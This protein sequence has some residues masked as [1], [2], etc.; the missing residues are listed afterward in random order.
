M[1]YLI[2]KPA[3]TAQIHKVILDHVCSSTDKVDG[4]KLIQTLSGLMVET[5]LLFDEPEEGFDCSIMKLAS[6]LGVTPREGYI[7]ENALPPSYVLD[8]ETEFGR[9]VARAFFEDWLNCAYEFHDLVLFIVHGSFMAMEVAQQERSEVFRLFVECTGRCLSY[10]LAAQ[11]LCDLVIDQKIGEE[12]W[13]VGE[14]ITGLSALAGR[15]IALLHQEGFE[16]DAL[17]LPV[18]LEKISYVMTQ[19][20]IRLGLSAGSDWR[21]GLAANDYHTSAPYELIVSLEPNVW[22]LFDSLSMQNFG[23][24][25]VS[26]AKAAGRMLAVAAGGEVPELEPVIAKPL[27]MAAMMETYRTVCQEEV[28]LSC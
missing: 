23:D 19:E 25:A 1:S 6:M 20:S 15:R 21:F 9:G 16:F 10:E 27:A 18:Q 7:G 11:E 24:Q 2:D 5:L 14:S 3:F 13:S 28:I 22:G 26:C 17:S 8:N 4:M 12:G